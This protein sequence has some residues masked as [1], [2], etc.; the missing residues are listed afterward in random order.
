MK[1]LVADSMKPNKLT[2]HHE[3]VHAK[4]VGKTPEF[5]NIKLN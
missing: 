3:T 4:Y 1:I 2:G 5:F